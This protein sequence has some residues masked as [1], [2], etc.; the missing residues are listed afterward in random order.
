MDFGV[1]KKVC[2]FILLVRKET[3]IVFKI[4]TVT[5]E[6][7]GSP[8][9][10]PGSHARNI[11]FPFHHI[12]SIIFERNEYNTNQLINVDPMWSRIFKCDIDWSKNWQ[13]SR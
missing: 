4:G 5:C 9:M 8:K 6:A 12:G 10:D 3:K 7:L 2:S 11:E 13:K 1:L